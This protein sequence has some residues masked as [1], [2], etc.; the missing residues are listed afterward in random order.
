MSARTIIAIFATFGFGVLTLILSGTILFSAAYARDVSLYV[1]AG[2]LGASSVSL[3]WLSWSL[4]PWTVA[5]K[6]L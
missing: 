4:S 3:L 5:W 1:I 2:V 6:V